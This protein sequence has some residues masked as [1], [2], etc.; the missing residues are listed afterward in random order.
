MTKGSILVVPCNE[1]GQGG[2]HL[3]RCIKLTR[4]LRSLGR[5]TWLFITPQTRDLTSF[6]LSLNFN[7]AWCIT[8]EE[9]IIR[10]EKLG[11][12]F[13]LLILDRFQTPLDELLKWKKIAPVIGIDEGGKYRDKFNFLIDMLI[14]EKFIHPTA[15]IYS[16][17]LLIDNQT[18]KN[19]TTNQQSPA[20]QKRLSGPTQTIRELIDKDSIFKILISFGQEDSANLGIK[21]IQKLSKIKSNNPIEIT[22]L[23]GS[24]NTNYS[25]LHTK[26]YTL[27]KPHSIKILESIPNL[28]QHLNEYNL[29][30]THYGITAYEA[31]FTG[32]PVILAHPTAYHKKLAKTS[33]FL[34]IKHLNSYI[35]S[36]KNPKYGSWLKNKN[37]N[38]AKTINNFSFMINN[39]CPVCG[40]ETGRA[41]SRFNDRTYYRCIKCSIIYMDRTCPAP[42]EYEKEY[43]FESYKKQYG[44]TYLEDF[45]NIKKSG[46]KRINVISK[47]SHGGTEAR[48]TRRE[49]KD[50]SLK[51]LDIGCAYG[52]F[53]AAAKEVNYSPFGIDPAEDAIKY[54]TETL[55]IPAIHSFFPLPH[56]ALHTKHLYNVITLW[57][58]IEHFTDNVSVLNEV[59]RLLKPGGIL[60]FSTPSYTGISGHSSIHRFLSK[61]PADHWTIWSPKS[62][63]KALAIAGFKVKKIVIVGH[64]PE[65]FPVLGKL[66]KNKKSPVYW[67]LLI[68]SKI[69]HL[70]DTFEV[71][72][73]LNEV[74]SKN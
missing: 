44:K 49:N 58:V 7:P 53:L 15:N 37:T 1:Q 64:H 45:D 73:E 74:I 9:L 11:K 24:L 70:G 72:A 3:T 39:N 32:T 48:R 22:L 38:L 4:D 61:S 20:A 34:D 30:I 17:Y 8:S 10:N 69:F 27:S 55:N 47:I 33:G 67:L 41:I 36:T 31:V 66:A 54:L 59:K 13:D 25:T 52:P 14:P 28:S 26:H 5:E 18:N 63:R 29:L 57:F 68:I 6:Y 12:T 50:E 19:L 21:T 40:S 56:S 42:I 23:K 51:L 43:F 2:G 46:K 60:A 71:Y 62:A 65:R 35:N 16:P